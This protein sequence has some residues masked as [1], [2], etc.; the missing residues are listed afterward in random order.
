MPG[1][2]TNATSANGVQAPPNGQLWIGDHLGRGHHHAP[3]QVDGTV[4]TTRQEQERHVSVRC[5]RVSAM[6]D[7]LTS[8]VREPQPGSEG[9][10]RT[11][12][13]KKWEKIPRRFLSEDRAREMGIIFLLQGCVGGEGEGGGEQC[14]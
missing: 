1:L 13:K 11:A 14:C 7:R 8:G 3:P 5:S 12:Q 2:C 9:E 10:S 6:W 4:T